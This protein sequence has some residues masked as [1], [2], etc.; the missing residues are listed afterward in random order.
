MYDA[1]LLIVQLPTRPGS[2][3]R[4]NPVVRL[5]SSS[6]SRSLSDNPSGPGAAAAWFST[7]PESR[8]GSVGTGS[9]VPGATGRRFFKQRRI[10]LKKQNITKA[11]MTTSVAPVTPAMVAVGGGGFALGHC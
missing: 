4:V 2:S 1:V 6:R 8:K 7:P 9:A 3:T 10:C 11:R 5:I